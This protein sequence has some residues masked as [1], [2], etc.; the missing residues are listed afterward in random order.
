M[1]VLAAR[2]H[3]HR[4]TVATH[5]G[6]AGVG[7]RRQGVPDE[8]R[9]EAIGLYADGWSC[10]RLAE[11][12]DC[13]DETVRQTLKLAGVQLRLPRGVRRRRSSC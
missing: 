11:R 6:R 8:L 7:L 5:L 13:V 12:Y 9:G 4:T 3:L 2:W 10:R 1:N